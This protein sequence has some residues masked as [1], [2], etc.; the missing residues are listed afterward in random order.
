MRKT[1]FFPLLL[2]LVTATGFGQARLVEKVS[3]RGNEIVPLRKIPPPNGLTL[4][5][6]K[7]TATRW[8]MWMSRTMWVSAREEIGKVGLCSFFRTHDVPGK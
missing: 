4:I 6:P 5:V 1:P 3:K 8:C 2:V 7:T